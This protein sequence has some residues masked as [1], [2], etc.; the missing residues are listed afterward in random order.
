MLSSEEILGSGFTIVVDDQT[1]QDRSHDSINEMFQELKEVLN[2]NGFDISIVSSQED[3]MRFQ[4]KILVN[5][6]LEKLYELC[7]E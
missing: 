4:G 2:R 3:A 7:K 1:C 6:M 5:Q